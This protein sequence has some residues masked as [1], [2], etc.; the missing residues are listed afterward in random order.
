[1]S[2]TAVTSE[3]SE[4]P[5]AGICLVDFTFQAAGPYGTMLLAGL[6]AEVIKIESRVR[7][8]PTRGRENRP[9][10][11]S[12][13]FDDVNLG[14]KSVAI[15]MKEPAGIA[16]ARRLVSTADVVADNFRPGVMTRWGM[17][18]A[19]LRSDHRQLVVASLSSTGGSGPLARLPGYAGI[20]NALGGLGGLTGYADG[21]PTEMRTSVD[22]RVGALFATAMLFGLLRA[23]RTGE[24][25]VIDFSAAEA[26]ASLIGDEIARYTL[27]GEV[28]ARGIPAP[29]RQ[30]EMVLRCGDDQWLAVAIGDLATWRRVEAVLTARGMPG[31]PGPVSYNELKAQAEAVSGAMSELLRSYDRAEA[32]KELTQ[33][34]VITGPV[35]A[36]PEMAADPQHRSR[37]FFRPV[38]VS[39]SDKT[40]LTAG[41]PWL[42]AS[43]RRSDSAAPALG[44]HTREIL[45]ERLNL[46][47]GEVDAL[48]ADG[49]LA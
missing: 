47:P 2:A 17:S 19:E 41:F 29:G 45:T 10:I 36:A 26:V 7:P 5:L 33:L 25:R 42:A 24:G 28:P 16:V 18:A 27:T 37:A 4:F 3:R 22:M 43:G 32:A 13:F 49:I 9:Y 11:H 6:G 46:E 1:M 38:T 39:G 40:R 23:K 21:P 30:L 20:F 35:M 12:V 14:K 44:Q 15:N 8:D 34:G 31:V 48:M